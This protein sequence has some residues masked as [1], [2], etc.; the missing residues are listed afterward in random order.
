MSAP[1]LDAEFVGSHMTPSTPGKARPHLLDRYKCAFGAADV[2]R[3]YRAGHQPAVDLVET[4]RDVLQGA[5]GGRRPALDDL[6]FTVNTGTPCDGGWLVVAR[7]TRPFPAVA[8]LAQT[9]G[10]GWEYQ[11]E[12]TSVRAVAGGARRP[13]PGATTRFIDL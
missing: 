4:L 1:R 6:D 12:R 11:V 2:M 7:V 13:D 9:A 8:R 3:M 5:D 10:G